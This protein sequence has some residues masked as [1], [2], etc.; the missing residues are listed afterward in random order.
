[1][2]ALS[3]GQTVMDPYLEAETGPILW[4]QEWGRP[5]VAPMELITHLGSQGVL[6]V[7]VAT[8][9]WCV[10][11][12]LGARMFVLLISSGVVNGL[13]KSLSYSPRPYWY[14]PRIIGY[15]HHSG[16]GMPSGH[17]QAAVVA[18]GYPAIRSGRRA[19]MWAAAVVVL[20]V[21]FS[22]VLLGAHFIG[23]VVVGLALGILILWLF[24]R[25]EDR[26]LAWWRGL[27][28]RRMA[29]WLLI[30]VLTPCVI[31]TAWQYGVRGDWTVPE[32][33]WIGPTPADPA[34]ASLAGLYTACGG[35]LGGVAGLTL[36]YRRGWYSADGTITAR[37]ARFVLG[38]SVLVILLVADRILFRDLTGLALALV[39]FVV[40]AAAAF[41]ASYGAPRAFVRSGLA[42]SAAVEARGEG[43]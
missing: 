34:G 35:L 30:V 6:I 20:L 26:V 3:V 10:H 15:H 38:F 22:R 4:L 8:V 43:R 29:L 17:S 2:N 31:A 5:L 13:F 23:D 36:L 18:W 27:E 11:A 39:S 7:L 21:A 33:E 40:Y 42:A 12:G 9:F 32:A 14:D 25:Y 1:M 16:F 41:W 37:V 28:P 19:A 24:L